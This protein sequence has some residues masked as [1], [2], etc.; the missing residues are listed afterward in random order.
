MTIRSLLATSALALLLVG[1][2]SGGGG[3]SKNAASTQAKVGIFRYPIPTTPTTL[4]PATVEDGDTID[5]L[6]QVFEGLVAWDENNNVIPMLAEKWEIS[7]DGTNYTFTLR[8]GV[9]FH[10]GKELTSEDVKWSIER[11]ANPTIKSAVAGGYMGDI[12]GVKEVVDGKATE[13]TG[14]TTPDPL[15]VVIKIDKPRPYFLGKFTYLCSAVMPKGDVP[16]TAN[17]SK[18]AEMIGTGPFTVTEYVPDQVVKLK[19][20]KDYHGGAPRV[21]GIERPIVKDGVVRLNMFRTGEVDLVALERQDVAG[22]K[23]D[24]ELKDQLKFY[25]RPSVYYVGLNLRKTKVFENRKLRQAIAMAINK[26]QI[27]NELMGGQ[28]T[29]A[30]GVIPPGVLGHRD[31]AAV[32]PYDV[33]G[34]KKM[35]AEAGFP[36]GKG[37]PT[38]E[39]WCRDGRPDVKL[40]TEAV[41]TQLDK[42]IG[43]KTKIVI[44]EWGAYLDARNNYEIPFCHMR[45]AADYLDPE[46]FVSFFFASYG[47]ENRSGY[48]NPAVDALTSRADTMPLGE[49]RLK[50]Y[51]EAEDIALQDAVLIPIYFQRDAELVS[52]RVSGQRESIFGHLPHTTTSVK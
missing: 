32:L 26:D 38:I 34:A 15:T 45:W 50:L 20:F 1:C 36:G 5:V 18:P 12:V 42:N 35:L 17:I 10:N 11:A 23:A 8:K 4:D 31:K 29:V 25:D 28:N 46:N 9:K 52:P 21:E 47:A 13:V 44:K 27:V 43:L 40:V 51:H 48:A 41:S 30:N 24:P 16:A 33:E 14:I 6:Q 3:F 37:L 7:P 39:L 2:N 49:D 19:A 22:I